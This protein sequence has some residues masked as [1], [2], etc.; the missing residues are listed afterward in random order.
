MSDLWMI[1][2]LLGVSIVLAVVVFNWWQEKKY[3]KDVE[4]RFSHTRTDILDGSQVK[5]PTSKKQASEKS[6]EEVEGWMSEPRVRPSV[7][8]EP[9]FNVGDN[10]QAKSTSAPTLK[11]PDSNKQGSETRSVQA[12]TNPSVSKTEP[13]FT[14][15]AYKAEPSVHEPQYQA[16]DNFSEHKLPSLEQL[17]T[18]YASSTD[19]VRDTNYV[20]ES[21]P[22]TVSAPVLPV[23]LHTAMDW[24]GVIDAPLGVMLIELEDLQAEARTFP[25]HATLWGQQ[26]SSATWLDVLAMDTAAMQNQVP[27]SL[28]ICSLQ[29]ADRGGPVDQDTLNRFQKSME[30]L[31][32][33]LGLTIHW[34]GGYDPSQQAQL[35][36]AFCIEV[37]KAVEFHVLANQGMFHAT[38]LRGLAEASGMQLSPEGRF[39]LHNSDG[40]LEFSVRNY[41]GKPF[42]GE[43]LKTAVMTGVTF[44]LD[45]PT[46]ASSLLVFDRMVDLA[47]T[48]AAS[49]SA[50]LIDVNRKPIG[51]VQLDKIRQQLNNIS[52][53]MA[54]QGITPGSAHAKRL[55]S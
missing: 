35:I 22:E 40:D 6:A 55:F 37:D 26:A 46:T 8:F 24:V 41:E 18:D 12:A 10:A 20:N 43:M 52:N 38:K 13:A 19:S 31:A 30:T 44:Q 25:H 2:V 34:Q 48:M 16:A 1:L 21:I 49:L 47:R 3:R 9:E 29:L 53:A 32:R 51:D 4:Y 5:E 7:K 36:D 39:E 50:S 17:N 11:N 45:I 28:V 27:L 33:A 42:S 54:K 14:E 15:P 23:A